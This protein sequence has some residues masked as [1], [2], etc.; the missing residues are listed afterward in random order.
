ME[1]QEIYIFRDDRDAVT[2]TCFEQKACSSE[3][4]AA[5]V[6]MEG[7][8]S[9][10]APDRSSQGQAPKFHPHVEKKFRVLFSRRPWKD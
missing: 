9:A 7:N 1:R 2:D 6:E 4:A 8:D 3:A 10:A 5:S